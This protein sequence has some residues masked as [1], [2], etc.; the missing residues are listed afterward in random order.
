[1]HPLSEGWMKE[2][3][4]DHGTGGCMTGFESSECQSVRSGRRC[5][6]LG[7]HDEK[8]PDQSIN[9]TAARFQTGHA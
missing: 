6:L 8:E 4:R 5:L 9:R 2:R 7:D 3:I 1:M